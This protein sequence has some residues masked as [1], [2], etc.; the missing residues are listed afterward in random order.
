M[1]G[2]NDRGQFVKGANRRNLIGERY[3]R[4]TVLERDLSKN[5]RKSYWLC[6]CD[7]GNTKSIRGDSLSKIQSCGRVKKEQDKINLDISYNHNMTHNPLFSVWNAMM[8]RCYNQ[9]HKSY[10]NYGGRGICVCEEWHDVKNFCEWT[11]LSGYKKSYTIERI[12]VDSDYEPSNCKWIPQN[13]QAWNTRKTVY[14][15]VNG[16]SIPLAKTARRLGI[17]PC[18]V[19][20]RWKRGIT[21]FDKLFFSGNLQTEYGR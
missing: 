17:E 2:R 7:C 5:S 20:H 14:I 8:N 3:G 12:D 21:D 4:L 1:E 16:K 15:D 6:R 10:E 13:E 11:K 18:L 19:W 9:N